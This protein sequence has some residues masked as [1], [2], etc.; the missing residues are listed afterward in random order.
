MFAVTLERMLTFVLPQ[1]LCAAFIVM[2]MQAKNW[3]LIIMRKYVVESAIYSSCA[4]ARRII[5]SVKK[6]DIATIISPNS[7]LIIS[8][9][10]SVLDAPIMSPS[11]R[12]LATTA[13]TPMLRESMHAI[14]SM[15]G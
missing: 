15:R 11:P 10:L 3:P 12:L 5:G 13:V 1:P 2:P 9:C 6:Q 8:D 14:I 4:P 7:T